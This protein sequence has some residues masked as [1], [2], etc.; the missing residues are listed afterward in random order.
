MK[1]ISLCIPT[2]NRGIYLNNLLS[3]I[4]L[5]KN[6]LR[7][8]EICISDNNSSDE[9][10]SI[11][12]S[13]KKKISIKYKKNKKNI[14]LAANIIN[15]SQMATGEFIWLIGD[16]DI[17][18]KDS[19]KRL[20]N[21]IASNPGVDF[22]YVNAFTMSKNKIKKNKSNYSYNYVSKNFNRFSTYTKDGQLDFID[23]INPD[24]SFDY[25]G[26][27][28][29]SVFKKKKWDKEISRVKKKNLSNKNTFSDFDNTFPHIKIF[30]FAF[31][32]S[33]AYFNSKPVI[34][35]LNDVREWLS[36]YPLIRSVRLIEAL[37]LYRK[38]GLVLT[39]FYMYKNYS[40]QYFI[41]DMVYAY[42]NK[43]ISGY[44][45]YKFSEIFLNCFLYPNFYFS[46]IW[47]LKRKI[48]NY[49]ATKK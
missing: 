12:K 13:Y 8:V 23:L 41:P 48:S 33:K 49:L 32:D 3:S 46:I 40:L 22:F 19:I 29:L 1:K 45:H 42:L 39:K 4:F 44:K 20:K 25:L 2:Y 9:T 35:S 5:N 24:I 7:N 16:D 14:G 11:I 18:F 36:N 47:Y 30:A 28:F 10:S 38:N 21:L 15:V 37:R 26:G 31:K 6:Y 34:I 17:L 43:E 27:I